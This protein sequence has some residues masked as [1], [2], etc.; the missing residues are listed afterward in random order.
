[1]DGLCLRWRGKA[2]ISHLAPF[3]RYYKHKLWQ[4]IEGNSN[5]LSLFVL[6]QISSAATASTELLKRSLVLGVIQRQCPY[7]CFFLS[8]P[9]VCLFFLC[10]ICSFFLLFVYYFNLFYL[11]VINLLVCFSFLL[12][13]CWFPYLFFL[14]FCLHFVFLSFL[15]LSFWTVCCLCFILSCFLPFF[16]VEVKSFYIIIIIKPSL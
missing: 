13:I 11:S 7:L 9:S 12:F 1:M 10:F 14:S 4:E 16:L 5:L 8:V 15:F 2:E 3:P 6:V